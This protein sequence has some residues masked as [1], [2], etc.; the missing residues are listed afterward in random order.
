ME[1]SSPLQQALEAALVEN[2]DDLATHS[3]YADYLMEQDDPRGEFIQMQL[4]LEDRGRGAEERAQLQARA[5]EL[6]W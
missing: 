2:P 5:D 3:A 4:A 6:L 1:S